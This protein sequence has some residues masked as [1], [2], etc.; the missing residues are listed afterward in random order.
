M[1]IALGNSDQL[2]ECPVVVQDAENAPLRA[3]TRAPGQAGLARPAAAVDLADD[4]LLVI[5]AAKGD[6]DEL[7]SEHTA[8][9]L[10]ALD[11]LQVGFADARLEY[12][13]EYFTGGRHGIRTIGVQPDTTVFEH[14]S[15][16]LVEDIPLSGT[17]AQSRDNH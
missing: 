5:D 15:A 2:R 1:Q 11:Q 3:V 13:D 7:V 9:A 6:A 17:S 16:H 12:A 10:V 4:A 8:K 14:E